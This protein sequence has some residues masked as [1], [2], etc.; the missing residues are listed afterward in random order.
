MAFYLC[1][2]IERLMS[3]EEEKGKKRGTEQGEKRGR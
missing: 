2:H 1:H 3:K